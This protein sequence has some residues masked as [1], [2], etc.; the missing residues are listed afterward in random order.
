MATLGQRW[1]E[2]WLLNECLLGEVLQTES[3]SHSICR[4]KTIKRREEKDGKSLAKVRLFGAISGEGKFIH[5]PLG[6][7]MQLSLAESS[8]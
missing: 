6:H 5:R 4:M 2:R 1:G 3:R 8:E 7:F